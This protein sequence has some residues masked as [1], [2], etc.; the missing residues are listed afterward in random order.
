MSTR[1]YTRIYCNDDKIA[2]IGVPDDDR[3][4][5]MND[6]GYNAKNLYY[7]LQLIIDR[8]YHTF[9]QYRAKYFKFNLELVKRNTSRE[10]VLKYDCPYIVYKQGNE[11]WLISERYWESITKSMTTYDWIK[12]IALAG[13]E[14]IPVEYYHI[15]HIKG[16]L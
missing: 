2:S 5:V 16:G 15:N 7:T 8:M 3:M 4:L 9:K 13:C 11:Y 1:Y 6:F 10:I 12:E 14:I